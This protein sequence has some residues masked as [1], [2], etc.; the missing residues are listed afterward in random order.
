MGL[1]FRYEIAIGMNGRIWV[2]ANSISTTIFVSNSISQIESM[3]STQFN[4]MCKEIEDIF[5][6]QESKH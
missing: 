3:T 6:Q 2:K 1:K 4:E 5:E